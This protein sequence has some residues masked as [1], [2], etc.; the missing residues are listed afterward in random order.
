MDELAH[1]FEFAA[2]HRVEVAARVGVFVRVCS[3]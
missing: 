3:H 2:L 1:V